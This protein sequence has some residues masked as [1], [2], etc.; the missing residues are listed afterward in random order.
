VTT[1]VPGCNDVVDDGETGFAVPTQDWLRLADAMEK[2][3]RSS[4]LRTQMGRRMR[5]KIVNQFSEAI[6]VRQTMDFYRRALGSAGAEPF[7]DGGAGP[8]R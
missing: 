6:V 8:G 2:L 5:E 3:A 4:E 7:F 1:D